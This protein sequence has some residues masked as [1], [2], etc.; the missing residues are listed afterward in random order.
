MYIDT[1]ARAL[2]SESQITERDKVGAEESEKS[3]LAI[4][5]DRGMIDKA[6]KRKDNLKVNNISLNEV[7]TP[8]KPQ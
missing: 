5:S 2:D 4:D 1:E 8:D 7:K 6:L 3:S